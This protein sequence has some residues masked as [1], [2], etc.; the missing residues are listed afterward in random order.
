MAAVVLAC[1]A[2]LWSR[3]AGAR[4]GALALLTLSVSFL[5][6]LCNSWL[7]MHYNLPAGHGQTAAAINCTIAGV[8]RG[9]VAQGGW[10]AAVLTC[11]PPMR[12]HP[13]TARTRPPPI[14]LHPSGRHHHRLRGQPPAGVLPGLEPRG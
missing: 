4:L 3:A 5:A 11:R 8:A 13:P 7:T 10:A 9:G 1:L 12:L 2:L 14:S 6:P